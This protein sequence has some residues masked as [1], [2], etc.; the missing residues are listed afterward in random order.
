MNDLRTTAGVVNGVAGGE[1]G[2]T[3]APPRVR[4]ERSDETN[5]SRQMSSRQSIVERARRESA[6]LQDEINATVI[7]APSGTEP[8]EVDDLSLLDEE[9]RERMVNAKL[10][11]RASRRGADGGP[12]SRPSR[13]RETPAAA[14]SGEDGFPWTFQLNEDE[15]P[16]ELQASTPLLSRAFRA[17]TG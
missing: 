9:A 12:D 8:D 11:E 1:G 16:E 6:E 4:P 5:S 14:T 2:I 3:S 15:E 13:R 10:A 7:D 17:T